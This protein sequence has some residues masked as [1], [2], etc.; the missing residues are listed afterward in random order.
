[1][2]CPYCGSTV[3]LRDADFIYHSAKSRK[4][5]K[6]WVC[7]KFPRCNSYVGCHR[8]TTLPLGRLANERLRTLKT[9]AHKQFDPIWKSGLMTRK[10]AYKWLADMLSIPYEECHIGMFDIKMCQRVIHLCKEQDNQVLNE[11][12]EKH[13]GV[14]EERPV[15]SRGYHK[16]KSHK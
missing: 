4:W 5:G 15:F 10:E 12:R 8:G 16:R 2:K 7:S 3:V 1:M 11:F 6:M 13:Y 14:K 9:E